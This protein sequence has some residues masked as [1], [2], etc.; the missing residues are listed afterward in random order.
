MIHYF[1]ERGHRAD[2]DPIGCR[3]N[4]P[5]FLDSAQIDHSLGLLDSILQPVEAVEPSGQHQ[6]I[7]SVL[8]EKLLCIGNG[9]RLIQLE[10]GHYVSYDSHNSP[11]TLHQM[12]AIRGCCSGRPASSDVRIVSAFTG[13]RRK[14]S[15]PS[16]SESAFKMEAHP[17]ATGGSPTPRAPTGVS[18]SGMSNAVHCILT[19]TSRIVGGLLWWNRLE[20]ISP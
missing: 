9:T 5:Q 20:T 7:A 8:F 18:G 19:G 15:S 17:P 10:S 14:T 13:A 4:S 2:F 16:A 11:S 12:W 3:A 6:G 1:S